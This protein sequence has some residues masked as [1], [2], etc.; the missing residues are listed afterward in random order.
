[1]GIRPINFVELQLTIDGIN[2]VVGGMARPDFNGVRIHG[3]M[4][5]LQE[6]NFNLLIGLQPHIQYNFIAQI[7]G[8]RY[9]KRAVTDFFP[10]SIELFEEIFEC[11]KPSRTARQHSS[12]P[13]RNVVI[14]CGEGFGRT[15]TVLAALKLKEL[16]LVA[17]VSEEKTAVVSLN[18]GAVEHGLAPCTPLVKH[19]IEIIRAIQ[20]NNSPIET[21][22]QVNRLCEYQSFLANL[23]L[24][25]DLMASDSS[26]TLR[27]EISQQSVCSSD[28]H[29]DE[30]KSGW[31]RNMLRVNPRFFIAYTAAPNDLG[32]CDDIPP[33]DISPRSPS[34]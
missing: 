30:G 21:I 4:Q 12:E 2:C 6:R 7:Y 34:P 19:A 1:M 5:Y 23:Q 13:S 11:V 22:G 33:D 20:G 18:Y 15:G 24:T 32:N 27:E 10:P 31:A 29:N 25:L 28:V 16:M 17:P 3:C 14:H 26:F 8:I 9:L